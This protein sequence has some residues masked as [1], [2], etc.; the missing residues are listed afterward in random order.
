MANGYE[1]GRNKTGAAL[2][3]S[4]LLAGPQDFMGTR[5][6]EPCTVFYLHDVMK[7]AA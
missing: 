4:F 2:L 6:L 7:D 5:I 3:L 1:Y